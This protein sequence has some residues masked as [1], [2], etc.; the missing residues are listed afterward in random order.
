MTQAEFL[1]DLKAGKNYL[2]LVLETGGCAEC[3]GRG[4]RGALH[5][6]APCQPCSGS[7][8]AITAYA[9]RW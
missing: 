9:V 5:R 8:D 4:T 3:F 6:N 2:A 7:G 1:A